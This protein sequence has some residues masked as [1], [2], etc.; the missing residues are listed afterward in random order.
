M[1]LF[2]V[3]KVWKDLLAVVDIN[4]SPK[5]RDR[6]D[7][8]DPRT[9]KYDERIILDKDSGISIVLG[10]GGINYYVFFEQ[11]KDYTKADHFINNGDR[12]IELNNCVYQVRVE[13]I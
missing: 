5:A 10:S 4:L 2:Q 9:Y 8:G 11:G 6:I 3:P 12:E 7:I 1:I 13:L